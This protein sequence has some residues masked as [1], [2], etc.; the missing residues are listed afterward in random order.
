[1]K[2]N[3]ATIEKSGFTRKPDFVISEPIGVKVV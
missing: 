1:M 2:K 3:T